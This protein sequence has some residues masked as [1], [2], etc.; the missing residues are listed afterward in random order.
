[1]A[2]GETANLRVVLGCVH[3]PVLLLCKDTSENLVA[4]VSEKSEREREREERKGQEGRRREG[5]GGIEKGTAR[6]P[7]D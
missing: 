5:T 7:A 6:Y 4:G 1:M 3:R 2:Q